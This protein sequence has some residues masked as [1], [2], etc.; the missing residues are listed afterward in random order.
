[1]FDIDDKDLKQYEKNLNNV[2]KYAF[3]DTVR[4]TLNA[5]AYQTMVQYKK[6]V[7]EELVIR[8]PKTIL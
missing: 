2:H 5:E 7:R 3:I 4:A 1:M 8:T 6:N